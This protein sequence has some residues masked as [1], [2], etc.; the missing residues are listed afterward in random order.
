MS[1]SPESRAP[2]SRRPDRRRARALS[3]LLAVAALVLAWGLLRSSE[4]RV[5]PYYVIQGASY[6][7]I[8]PRILFVLDTSGS[9]GLQANDSDT[10]CEWSECE[11]T[12]GTQTASRIATAR[13]AINSVVTSVGDNA[14]FG[15]M[16][17]EQ[18]SPRTPPNVPGKCAPGTDEER[19]FT[20]VNEYSYVGGFG[21]WTSIDR[22]AGVTGAWRLCQGGTIRPYPYLR[23]DELGEGSVISSNAET[24]DV[25]PSPLIS[26]ASGSIDSAANAQR[27]VQW[28][29]TFMG[30]RV[31]LDDTNDPDH[32]ITYN[33]IGDWGSSNADRDANV[34]GHDFYYWPYV[35]GFPGYA[36]WSVRPI[37]DGPDLSLIH[38]SEPTRPY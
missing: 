37:S 19:R 20:W 3:S 21:G 15:L 36:Q 9:M 14:S 16:T 22:D 28:F 13:A 4:A 34:R 29:R 18:V 8:Q 11:S 5:R 10:L 17:F 24:G 26:T 1:P 25:P 35:D 32:S 6:G 7:A 2:M 23:W 27:R 31:H 38:I 33:T 30:V 12:V